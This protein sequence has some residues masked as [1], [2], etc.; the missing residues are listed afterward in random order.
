[1]KTNTLLTILV[2]AMIS[3]IVL[4]IALLDYG[5]AIKET[6]KKQTFLF[7]MYQIEDHGSNSVRVMGHVLQG[8]IQPGEKVALQNMEGSLTVCEILMFNTPIEYAIK[9]DSISLILCNI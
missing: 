5:N 7:N 9:G 6:L 2:V 8:R 1:M 3:F 4:L